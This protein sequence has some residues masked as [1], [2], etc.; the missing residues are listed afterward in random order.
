MTQPPT[1][2]APQPPKE[3]KP[4]PVGY[5]FNAMQDSTI[6]QLASKMK[7]VGIFMIIVCSLYAILGLFSLMVSP[8]ITL[9]YLLF[10][11]PLFLMGLWTTQASKAFRQ[12]VDT[13]GHDIPFL[14]EA[15]ESLRKLYTLQFW[16]LIAGLVMIPVVIIIAVM[17]VS[18]GMI[19]MPPAS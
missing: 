19:P 12:V 13:K 7:F 9:I 5:E 8:L 15:L 17:I 3:Q 18:S 1:P 10:L 6:R 4:V 2:T 16:I 11:T 14:M